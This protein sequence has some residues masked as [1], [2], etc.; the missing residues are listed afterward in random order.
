MTNTEKCK[1][2]RERRKQD[3]ALCEL[4][5][6]KKEANHLYYQSLTPEMKE[7]RIV[8]ELVTNSFSSL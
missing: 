1:A 7:Q 2:R 4:D 3:P 8:M 5:K 6:A